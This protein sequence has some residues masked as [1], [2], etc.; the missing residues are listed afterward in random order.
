MDAILGRGFRRCRALAIAMAPCLPSAS[1]ATLS[2]A[3]SCSFSVS[4][5]SRSFGPAPFRWRQGGAALSPMSFAVPR[6]SASTTTRS[7]R[8][9]HGPPSQPP[10]SQ[11]SLSQLPSSQSSPPQPP[12]STSPPPSLPPCSQ[13]LHFKSSPPPHQEPF[14][15]PVHQPLLTV[16]AFIIRAIC[17]VCKGVSWLAAAYEMARKAARFRLSM[18]LPRPKAKSPLKG[19]LFTMTFP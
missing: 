6:L 13:P 7:P 11:P 10:H 9:E 5:S 16:A 19:P 17:E 15:Q 18:L 3:T 1:S 12:P 8:L 4:T 14:Q 2:S